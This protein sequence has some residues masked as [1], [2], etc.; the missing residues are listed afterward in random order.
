LTELVLVDFVEAVTCPLREIDHTLATKMSFL[1]AKP[2]RS[3]TNP[4]GAR[5]APSTLAGSSSIRQKDYTYNI[6]QIP[7]AARLD[8]TKT[9]KVTI[10]IH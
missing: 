8:L 5:R 9:I 6:V 4:M 2:R 10:I 3:N 7:R 1:L